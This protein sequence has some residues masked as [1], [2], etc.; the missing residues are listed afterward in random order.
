[1][2]GTPLS[3]FYLVV[4]LYPK[5]LYIQYIYMVK[6]W[7]G[8]PPT[9]LACTYIWYS[10][11]QPLQK[12]PLIPKFANLCKATV[13][14]LICEI[15][16]INRPKLEILETFTSIYDLSTC[17]NFLSDMMNLMPHTVSLLQHIYVCPTGL[18]LISLQQLSLISFLP[19]PLFPSSLLLRA[20]VLL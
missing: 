1:M 20:K 4:I 5:P 3:G 2:E 11:S 9:T 17:Q 18:T 7:S 15:K 19:F 14:L 8:H 10:K 16:L 12:N 6:P 13:L